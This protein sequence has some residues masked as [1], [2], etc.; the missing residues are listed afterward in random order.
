MCLFGWLLL[1]NFLESKDVGSPFGCQENGGKKDFWDGF[2][3]DVFGIFIF[4]F[5]NQMGLVLVV[6]IWWIWLKE[7]VWFVMGMKFSEI[8][9][10]KFSKPRRRFW[11]LG[12]MGWGW[13]WQWKREWFGGTSWDER[14]NRWGVGMEERETRFGAEKREKNH[15][16]DREDRI[17]G[18]MDLLNG[19]VDLTWSWQMFTLKCWHLAVCSTNQFLAKLCPFGGATPSQVVYKVQIAFCWT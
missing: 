12:S 13:D 4:Y 9:D 16:R 15:R 3:L 1:G 2:G 10:L 11:V 14:E 7:I 8:Q 5:E 17:N 18:V 19:H 6:V